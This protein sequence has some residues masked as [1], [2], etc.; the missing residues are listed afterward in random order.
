MVK[1]VRKSINVISRTADY[2]SNKIPSSTNLRQ[3]ELPVSK[4][5]TILSP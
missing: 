2:V 4:F 3:T 5:F 1:E